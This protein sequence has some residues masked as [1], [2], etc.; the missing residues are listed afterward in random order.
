M[1]HRRL[2]VPFSTRICIMTCPTI[3]TGDSTNDQSTPDYATLIQR[4]D[5]FI[6][7]FDPLDQLDM[8]ERLQDGLSLVP[9]A[10]RAAWL[11]FWLEFDRDYLLFADRQGWR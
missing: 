6:A 1:R 10:D 5:Q 8:I 9:D 2:V 7:T 11:R 3:T 4:A